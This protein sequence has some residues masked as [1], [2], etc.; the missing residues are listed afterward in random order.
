MWINIIYK[1]IKMK[2]ILFIKIYNQG[3]NLNKYQNKNKQSKYK[4]KDKQINYK[5]NIN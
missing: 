1:N 3:Q 4:N 5:I 2:L